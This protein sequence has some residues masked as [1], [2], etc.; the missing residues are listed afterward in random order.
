MTMP[1]ARKLTINDRTYAY[2]LKADKH[3]LPGWTNREIRLT[4]EFRPGEFFSQSF[5]SKLWT[6]NHEENADSVPPH[7][8]S[9]TPAD[10]RSVITTLE[11]NKGQLPTTFETGVW[12][13]LAPE[14]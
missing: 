7:K 5:E 3:R 12:K 1:G 8:A 13:R 11:F 6:D 4:V 14:G 9:F 2:K 10:V